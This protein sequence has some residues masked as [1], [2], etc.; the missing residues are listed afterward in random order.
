MN[1]R[2]VI[3]SF[4]PPHKLQD[5]HS[6][7]HWVHELLTTCFTSTY[8]YQR[9]SPREGSPTH[10]KWFILSK[11]LYSAHL[12]EYKPPFPPASPFL[13]HAASLNTVTSAASNSPSSVYFIYTYILDTGTHERSPEPLF[14]HAN[15]QLL[16]HLWHP[17]VHW[18]TLIRVK[19]TAAGLVCQDH[20]P[21]SKCHVSSMKNI[22]N[23]I[24]TAT[25]HPSSWKT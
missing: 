9:T 23:N 5:H 21:K 2:V 25:S 24:M 19:A 3:R 1:S 16:R 7:P 4:L 22:S 18:S 8:A 10:R 13:L 20:G 6:S 17:V 14:R 15:F 12:I 11:D